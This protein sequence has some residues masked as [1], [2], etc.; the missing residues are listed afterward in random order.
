M[1]FHL[2]RVFVPFSENIKHIG[3]LYCMHYD[4]DNYTAT[5]VLDECIQIQFRS[6]GYALNYNKWKLASL[7]ISFGI[8]NRGFVEYY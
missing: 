5:A 7:H 8:S 4:I 6:S 2:Q 1:I 3:T